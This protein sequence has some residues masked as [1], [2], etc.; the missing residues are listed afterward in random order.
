MWESIST[1]SIKKVPMTTS[2]A[3]GHRDALTTLTTEATAL[4]GEEKGQMPAVIS[5]TGWALKKAKPGVR[6]SEPVKEFLK[7]IFL[8][9][10]ETGQKA[11]P[12]E[13]ASK[14]RSVH[15]ITCGIIHENQ[16]NK[17]EMMNF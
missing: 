5:E 17:I 11:D 7:E 12:V 13:V 4:T 10:E 15:R 1:T 2:S 8:K 3:S 6:F 16:S 14:H 9:G